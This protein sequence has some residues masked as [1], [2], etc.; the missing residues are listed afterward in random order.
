MSGP[1][2]LSVHSEDD[3][4][5]PSDRGDESDQGDE[6]DDP[7]APDRN[8]SDET[9]TT[10]GKTGEADELPMVSEE[11][12]NWSVV[13]ALGLAGTG[14]LLGSPVLLA[15][16][17][18]PL[19]HAGAESLTGVPQA[20]VTLERELTLG[21]TGV[22]NDDGP[23]SGEPG[24]TVHVHLTVRN[25]AAMPLVDLRLVD[26]VPEALPVVEGSPRTCL[27]LDPGETATLEYAVE[28]QRGEHTFD[29][30]SIRARD[31]AGATTVDWSEGADGDRTLRCSPAVRRTPVGSASNDFGGD[32]PTD[33]GG[34]GIEFHSVREYEPGDAVQSI[35]W[36]RYAST[37]ELASVEYRAERSAR[38]L[39]LIDARAT[40]F[41]APADSELSIIELTTDAA[42]R[43]VRRLIGDG[44]PTGVATF[45]KAGLDFVAPGTSTETTERIT[46]LLDGIPENNV[47]SPVTRR[48]D[49]EIESSLTTVT[50]SSTTVV[51]FS[52]F[53]ED[54][55]L[56]I[57]TELQSLGY[58][59]SV[60]SPA[61][62]GGDPAEMEGGVDVQGLSTRLAALER[63]NRLRKARAS[64]ATVID[65]DLAESIGTVLDRAVRTVSTR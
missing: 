21:E 28:L 59:V 52:A 6:S 33:D 22:S 34:S 24:T 12:D 20:E 60:V 54:R 17:T 41:W 15:T 48:I 4:M 62:G 65:W 25:D 18:I 19:L 39:C 32:V 3:T 14:L 51:L 36:R 43:I 31:V 11:S 30:V 58:N 55:P 1:L 29:Q 40:Q 64:G 38:I 44:H 8:A 16:A 9:D 63:E 23:L 5:Q 57:L 53:L 46:T 27:T 37:R 42:E 47:V 2:E 45:D 56:T 61:V 26:G 49:G 7:V 13:L 35:D 50:D 10:D